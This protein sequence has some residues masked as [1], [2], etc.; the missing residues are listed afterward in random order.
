MEFNVDRENILKGLKKIQ[1]I[2]E[3]SS[4][5]PM[6]S[7]LLIEAKEK[8]IIMKATN[9]EVGIITE[10][11]ADV[12]K[13]GTTVVDAK[14]VFEIFKELPSGKSRLVKKETG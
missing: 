9:F 12:K 5:V 2:A 13:T 11:E 3:K 6:A 1:G 8:K 14:K 10:H 4:V 7:N